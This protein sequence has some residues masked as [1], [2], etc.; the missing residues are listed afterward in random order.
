MVPLY[1]TTGKKS[2][3]QLFFL[4]KNIYKIIARTL[5]IPIKQAV[6]VFPVPF[7]YIG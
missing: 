1:H 6:S 3:Q 7:L 5:K 4:G 2:K